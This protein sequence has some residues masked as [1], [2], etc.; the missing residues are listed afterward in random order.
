MLRLSRER[1]ITDI[2]YIVGTATGRLGETEWTIS[3]ALCRRERHSFSA[4]WHSFNIDI[5]YVE[6][7]EK[8]SN[9]WKLMIVAETWRDSAGENIRH[10]EWLKLL[11]GDSKDV[12]KW[13]S[14]NRKD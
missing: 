7:V 10:T 5:L 11:N 4:P 13:I 9:H 8:K 6:S 12:E 1:I 2:E 14:D 3:S